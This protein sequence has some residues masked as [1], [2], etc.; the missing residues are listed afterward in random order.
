[1]WCDMEESMFYYVIPESDTEIYERLS[2][3]D[4]LCVGADGW[5]AESFRS[6]AEKENGSV[7]C[8]SSSGRMAGD[9]KRHHV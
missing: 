8:C 5:S 7:M 2:E 4:R 3:L 9:R 1:M 6:E